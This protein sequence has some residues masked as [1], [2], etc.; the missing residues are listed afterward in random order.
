MKRWNKESGNQGPIHA[1]H[2]RAADDAEASSFE[3]AL[4]RLLEA[5]V[6]RELSSKGETHDKQTTR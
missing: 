3:A 4:R 5:W 6:D 1:V 2:R